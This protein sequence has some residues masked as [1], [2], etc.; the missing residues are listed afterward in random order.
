MA[1][2]RNSPSS[3]K[4]PIGIY[5]EEWIWDTVDRLESN[6]SVFFR[7]LLLEKLKKDLMD[8]DFMELR[9]ADEYLGHLYSAFILPK[10]RKKPASEGRIPLRSK[11]SA[12][13]KVISLHLESWIWNLVSEIEPNRSR[14]FKKLVLDKIKQ[15]LMEKDLIEADETIGRNHGKLFEQLYLSENKKCS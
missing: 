4:V 10:L 9:E 5:L 7:N 2:K 15:S 8:A 1:R 12:K 6:R 14:F 3:R 13:R 11:G